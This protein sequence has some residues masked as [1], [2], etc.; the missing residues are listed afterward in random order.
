LPRPSRQDWYAGEV[1]AYR[2]RRFAAAMED[3]SADDRAAF[4]GLLTRFVSALGSR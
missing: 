3:W 2:R 1:H 4:A